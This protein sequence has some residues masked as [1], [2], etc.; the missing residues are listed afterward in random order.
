MLVVM[1]MITGKVE[2]AGEIVMLSVFLE[3]H[4]LVFLIVGMINFLE[5]LQVEVEAEGPIENG[6][7]LCQHL[8]FGR[9]KLLGLLRLLNR[10]M[11]LCHQLLP[12]RQLNLR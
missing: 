2:V 12:I 1:D 4:E 9:G 8:L 7:V 10:V 11:Y 6:R 5:V 3:E